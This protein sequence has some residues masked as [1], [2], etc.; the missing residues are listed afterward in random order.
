MIPRN[1]ICARGGATRLPGSG[2]TFTEPAPCALAAPPAPATIAVTTPAAR[3]ALTLAAL[4]STPPATSPGHIGPFHTLLRPCAAA[5]R[6]TRRS[7]PPAVVRV[8]LLTPGRDLVSQI[9]EGG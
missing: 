4:T 3:T 6:N 5:G 7:Y 1:T 8:D 9:R 2:N